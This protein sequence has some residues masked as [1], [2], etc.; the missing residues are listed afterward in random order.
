MGAYLYCLIADWAILPL[1]QVQ[2][3]NSTGVT[4]GEIKHF[5]CPSRVPSSRVIVCA[6]KH[7]HKHTQNGRRIRIWPPHT[8][9]H[10]LRQHIIKPNARGA[11]ANKLRYSVSA[12]PDAASV[13]ENT[14]FPPQLTAT[15]RAVPTFTNKPPRRGDT[16]EPTTHT[17]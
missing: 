11:V 9:T 6:R 1:R 13:R 7:A 15:V 10:T 12:C 5:P 4:T 17:H 3:H 14:A 16:N 8:H 2:P